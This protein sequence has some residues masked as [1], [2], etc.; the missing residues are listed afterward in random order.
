MKIKCIG[1][2]NK[3]IDF[4]FPAAGQDLILVLL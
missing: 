2:V 4:G 3:M 1:N